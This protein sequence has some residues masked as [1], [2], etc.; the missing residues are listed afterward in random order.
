MAF[1]KK[2]FAP[3][4]PLAVLRKAFSR[5][6]WAEVLA[7]GAQI[8]S[9]I[10]ADLRSELETLVD[11]A[12]DHLAR[13]NL[14]EA[15]AFIRAGDR[16][17]AREHL[18]LAASQAA[19]PELLQQIERTRDALATAAPPVSLPIPAP[20]AGNDCASGCD[21]ADCRDDLTA[22]QPP[23]DAAELDLETRLELCLGG[24]PDHLAARYPGLDLTLKRAVVMAHGDE[25][26]ALEAFD[27]VPAGARDANF[28]YEKGVLLARSGDN[29]G[30]VTDLQ[31]CLAQ[32]I[33]HSL[34]GEVLFGLY[35]EQQQLE[36]ALELIEAL[37]TGGLP[38][39]F[40]KAR[41]AMVKTLTGAFEE[42]LELAAA[43]Y[44]DDNREQELLVLYG[45]LLERAGRIEE[46]EKVFAQTG[47]GGGCGGGAKTPLPLAE[48][49][50][51]QGR[52]PG[53]AL[54]CFKSAW[55]QDP[56]N[57]YWM[58]RIGQALVAGGGV[59]KGLDLLRSL[60]LRDDLSPELLEEANRVL[61]EHR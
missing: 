47:T 18:G 26:G 22:D 21:A 30:A 55:Q 34:A 45:Q 6:Q 44:S 53:P 8:E 49:W 46:A 57:P 16:T 32:E 10:D 7:L 39:R 15:E 4:D 9:T 20:R 13:V 12:R 3:A 40:W 27:K 41:K 42:A 19:D 31:L 1:F 50:L 56:E 17:L 14:A 37:A 36:P 24:Y 38:A 11:Q 43:A 61:A 29:A 35:L 28:Y 59:E 33:S 54:E 23:P 58:L 51:R 25:A 60:C 5:E 52:N 48:F 2:F